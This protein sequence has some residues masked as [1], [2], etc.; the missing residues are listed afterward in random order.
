[1]SVAVE[2]PPDEIVM[3]EGDREVTSPGSETD[4]ESATVPENWL[5]LASM[6]VTAPDVDGGSVILVGM[7]EILKSALVTLTVRLITWTL[8]PPVPVTLTV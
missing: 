3:V 6:I 7:L 5:R 4:G 2:D 1:M 8:D